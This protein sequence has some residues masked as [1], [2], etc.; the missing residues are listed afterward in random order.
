MNKKELIEL[1]AKDVGCAKKDAE[2]MME[3]FVKIVTN[4]LKKKERVVLVGF[5]VFDAKYRKP[6]IARNPQH[7]SQTVKVPGRNVPIF[8]AGKKLKEAVR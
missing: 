5:G 2:S 1:I 6:R 4:S 3:S 7:P 8:R